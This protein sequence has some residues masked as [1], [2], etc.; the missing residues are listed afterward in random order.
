MYNLVSSL[1]VYLSKNNFLFCDIAPWIPICDHF[2]DFSWPLV[3]WSAV[4]AQEKYCLFYDDFLHGMNGWDRQIW[5]YLSAW[6]VSHY[7]LIAILLDVMKLNDIVS[8]YCQDMYLIIITYFQVFVFCN[9]QGYLKNINY[10]APL[11]I[12]IYFLEL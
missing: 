3:V 2:T 7:F 5:K 1:R 4:C 11:V 8:L 10:T 9:V 6:K 12:P